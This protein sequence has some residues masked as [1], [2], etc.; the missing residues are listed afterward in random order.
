MQ[1]FDPILDVTAGAVDRFVQMPGRLIA[2]ST[3]W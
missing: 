3:R 2:Y 1:L